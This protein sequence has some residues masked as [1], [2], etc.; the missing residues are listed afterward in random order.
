VTAKRRK[1]V[2]TTAMA[3]RECRRR[4]WVADKVEQRVRSFITRDLFGCI[5][6]VAMTPEGRIVGLQVTGGQGGHHADRRA[7]ILAEPRMAQWVSCGAEL[8]LWSYAKRGAAGA[9]KLWVLRVETWAEMQAAA[10]SAAA[11]R[12]ESDAELIRDGQS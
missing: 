3:L 5:D 4:G 7:K 9:R 6:I 8:Q 1:P 12:A 2:S 10:G 11:G